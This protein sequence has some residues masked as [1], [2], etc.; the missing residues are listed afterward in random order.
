VR[1]THV[2]GFRRHIVK[3][4]IIGT[5]LVGLI[6]VGARAYYTRGDEGAQ[7]AAVE[8]TRGPIVA[9][10]EATGTLQAVTTVTV[11][12]QVS[13]NIAWLGADFNSIV[14]KGQVIAKLDPS[15]FQAQVAQAQANLQKAQAD[16]RHAEVALANAQTT[17]G[18]Q[19][20]LASRQ[21]IAASDLDAARVAVD[22]AQA[23]VQSSKAQEVQ[24]R[25]SLNQAQVSLDHTIITAPIDGIV[26]QR[27]V[28][29][30]QTVAASMQSPTIFL[31]A[32]DL[33]KMQV[34][35]DIDE[36]DIGQITNGE[37]VTFGVDAY[38]GQT[39][40]GTVSQ[41][42]LQPTVVSNVTTYNAI[43]DVP[44][45]DLRLKPGMTATVT[46]E[47]AR[48][49]EALR[50]PNAAL[51]FKPTEDLLA[52]LGEATD[53]APSAAKAA[54]RSAANHATRIWTLTDGRLTPVSVQ[55]GITDQKYTEA[56]GSTLAPGTQVVTGVTT[57]EAAAASGGGA[58]NPLLGG[59]R[60]QRR[61]GTR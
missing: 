35:A 13:G 18:R 39:F 60:S 59:A 29:V 30:G 7:I 45:P 42:R 4:L 47:V 26:I 28:D 20:Q 32:A 5:L 49:D 16:V 24:A 31:I 41:V 51:R 50:I 17:Y 57:T 38:P 37:P 11:G 25:A 9:T 44:N 8:I 46:V 56:L 1:I 61:T 19:Q 3:R 6:G 15:L 23:D 27:S 12:T 48:R 10:V 52:E 34:N 22:T 33:T 55:L 53:S 14:H 36:A 40:R 2:L 54:G 21:L 58:S 43:V